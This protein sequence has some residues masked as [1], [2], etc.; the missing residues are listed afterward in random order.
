M[1]AWDTGAFDNDAAAD[2]S[3]DLDELGPDDRVEAVRETLSSAAGEREHLDG[4]EGARAVAAAALVAAQ[5]PQG[6]PADPIYG[7]KEPL[8]DLP[9]DLRPLAVRALRRVLA[10]ESELAELWSEG[11]QGAHWREGVRRLVKVL[12]DN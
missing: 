10:A 9:V 2:F 1:G 4:D 7:P 3:G 12:A 11:E 5:C 6:D 8:P